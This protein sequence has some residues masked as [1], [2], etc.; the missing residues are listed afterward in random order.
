MSILP[1]VL[2]G[3]SGTRL[4]PLSRELYPKQLLALVGDN[5]M[6]QDTIRRL[7]GLDTTAPPL[8][9]C[10]NEH[11]FMVAEQL[12]QIGV[13]PGAIL[14]EP[15]GRNT[16]PAVAVAALAAA[17]N[18]RGPHAVADPLLLVLPADHVIADAA[19]LCERIASAVPV[20]A[21]GRLVTFGI[22]PTRPE[23]GYGYIRAGARIAP[24]SA[25]LAVDEFVEKP[26]HKTAQKY[27]AD[28]NY[29]WNSGMF[30]LQASRYLEELGRH[31]PDMLAACQGAYAAARADLDFLR[32][33][34]DGFAASPSNSIDYAVMEKTDRAAVVPLDVGWSD[35]GNWDALYDAQQPDTQGN[36]LIGDVEVVRS[37]NC[38]IHAGHRL[39]TALGLD[40][41]I[42]VETADAVF[43]AP[44]SEAQDVKEIVNRLKA[45]KRSEV[46]LHR[47]VFRPWGSADRIGSGERYRVNRLLIKPG[48]EQSLQ[49]HQ[50]RSEH[51]V[52]VRGT[53]EITC[54]DEVYELMEN[55][56]AYISVGM[57]H[58]IR[59]SGADPLE[60]IEIQ[61]GRAIDDN[62]IE[63]LADS[64]GRAGKD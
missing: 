5:T 30:L 51:W 41:Q 60:I 8:V 49:R 4:W 15:V 31:Q 9:V 38:Y 26:D 6:L 25:G 62:D 59:N 24:D 56:S 53:A 52:V 55:Q 46:Q 18:M 36:V 3:G 35:V 21:S 37:G 11:R 14:L 50:H 58:R 57:V 54:D 10:N 12:R 39:V 7:D 61:T 29:F 16:A 43:I 13:E 63:R 45:D 40:S 47:E 48:G 32:L 28:G 33:D 27:L 23:T 42:I 2:S 44:R 1:V 19:A 64:Y 34:P 22:T 17:D 20:A